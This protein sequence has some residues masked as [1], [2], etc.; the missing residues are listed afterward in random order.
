MKLMQIY[1]CLIAVSAGGISHGQTPQIEWAPDATTAITKTVPRANFS[2]TLAHAIAELSLEGKVRIAVDW[3]NL[4]PLGVTPET[5]VALQAKNATIEHLLDATLAKVAPKGVPLAWYI[6]SNIVYVTTQ[7]GAMGQTLLKIGLAVPTTRPEKQKS[8]TRFV[9][10]PIPIDFNETPLSD[11]I[12]YY[13][14]TTNLTF[15]VNWRSLEQVQI[16]GDT[17]V[18]VKANNISLARSLDLVL[19]EVSGLRSRFERLYWLVDEGMIRIATGAAFNTRISTRTYDV[20]DLMMRVPN[21]PGKPMSLTFK[22]PS[23]SGAGGRSLSVGPGGPPRHQGRLE[24]PP[25]KSQIAQQLINSIKNSIGPDMWSPDGKGTI[26]V[27]RG[28]LIIS[29][30]PLGYK[31]L[32]E[33]F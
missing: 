15:S 8:V 32:G 10:K 19:D 14:Q 33:T 17:P 21:M 9:A 12:A 4:R 27:R 11:V 2:S 28:R 24:K 20:T 23:G 22:A 29:Q 5:P 1:L 16:T 30:T 31:L 6:R 18:T 3:E 26:S 25:T 13:R 7:P